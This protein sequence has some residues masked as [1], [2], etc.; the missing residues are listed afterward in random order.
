MAFN[1][2]LAVDLDIS[3][4]RNVYRHGLE[5]LGTDVNQV[6]RA[7]REDHLQL[8][9]HKSLQAFL[10]GSD[11]E[12]IPYD[13]RLEKVACA[14]ILVLLLALLPNLTTLMADGDSF[15]RFLP[16]SAFRVFG[17][18]SIKLRTLYATH[19]PHAIVDV[20]PNLDERMIGSRWR[21]RH[22]PSP[23][24][25]LDWIAGQEVKQ[26]EPLPTDWIPM[27]W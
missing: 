25:I 16:P 27:I 23:G 22:V 1:S 21:V 20:A 13:R 7:R 4:A 15:D 2:N 26:K 6:R 3:L 11:V 12:T 19:L 9:D 5:T 17:I 18:S 14:E 10:F 8:D 24:T